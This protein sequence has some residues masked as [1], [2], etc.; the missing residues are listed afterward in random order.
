[1]LTQNHVSIVKGFMGQ[2]TGYDK[3]KVKNIV[4]MG[5]DPSTNQVKYL[6]GTLAREHLPFMEVMTPKTI[7]ISW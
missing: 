5:E 7:N 4:I 1:M 6:P 2:T 3:D